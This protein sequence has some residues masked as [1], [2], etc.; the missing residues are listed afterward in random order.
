[1][2]WYRGVAGRGEGVG[3]IILEKLT[4]YSNISLYCSNSLNNNILVV[5][6]SHHNQDAPHNVFVQYAIVSTVLY[7]LLYNVQ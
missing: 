4:Y 1:M 5:L 7:V 3:K 2:Y 6:L